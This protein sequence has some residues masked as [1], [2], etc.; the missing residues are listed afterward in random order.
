MSQLEKKDLAMETV[1]GRGNSMRKG[2]EVGMRLA[3]SVNSKE[4]GVAGAE[5]EGQRERRCV[6]RQQQGLHCVE[7]WWGLIFF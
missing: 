4:A 6:S 2:P 5:R 3:C 1:A 7:S